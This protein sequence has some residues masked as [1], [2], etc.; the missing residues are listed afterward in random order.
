[1]VTSLA[2]WDLFHGTCPTVALAKHP[3]QC[4]CPSAGEQK[5]PQTRSGATAPCKR[6]C[7]TTRSIYKSCNDENH[8]TKSLTCIHFF[9]LFFRPSF[10][11]FFL[12][13]R[14][15]WL[16]FFAAA[17]LGKAFICLIQLHLFA[18][19]SAVQRW[20]KG[21]QA[22]LCPFCLGFCVKAT[23]VSTEAISCLLEPV[24]GAIFEFVFVLLSA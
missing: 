18:R 9:L 22:R 4:R 10:L 7:G 14:F 3:H 19:P 8:W 11:P 17:A 15:C 24:A 12:S 1:V 5:L 13:F 6:L 2:P 16:F 21:A 20:G 23:N